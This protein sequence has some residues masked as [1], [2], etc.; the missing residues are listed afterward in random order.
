MEN[1]GTGRL[2]R[3]PLPALEAVGPLFIF[4]DALKVFRASPELLQAD[5]QARAALG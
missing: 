3:S 5:V 1:L 2:L 4:P